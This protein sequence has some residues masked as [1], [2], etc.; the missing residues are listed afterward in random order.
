MTYAQ[1]NSWISATR[2]FWDDYTKWSLDVAP[3]TNAQSFILI[4]NAA[5]KTVSIDEVTSGDFP[6]TMTISNLSVWAPADSTNTLLI[7]DIGTNLPLTVLDSLSISNGG[8]LVI[9]NSAVN[10]SGPTNSF[11]SVGGG[12]VLANGSLL[13]SNVAALGQDP[14]SP[15][16]LTVASGTGSFSGYLCVGLETN[17]VGDVFLLGG[18]LLLT[19][20]PIAVGLY[21]TG[22]LTVTNNSALNSD[23]PVIVG[24]GAGSQGAVTMDNGSWT[25]S[26]HLVTGQDAGAQG[27]VRIN[28]GQLTVTNA[29]L[30]LIGGNGSGQHVWSN[31][32]VTVGALEIGAGH[33][34]QGALT[35]A[36]GTN[37]VQGALFVGTGLTA[38]GVVWMTG[39][40]LITTNAPSFIAP[41]GYGV[42]T[43]SNG[44]WLGNSMLLGSA[45]L[46]TITNIV[47]ELSHGTLNVNGG[48]LTLLAKLVVG[49]CALP[50]SPPFSF[51]V[52]GVGAVNVD[53]GNLYVTNAAHNAFIEVR[54]GTFTLN[55]GTVIVDTF[56]MTNACAH[57]A[58]TG[59]T[60][61]YGSAVLVT[62][63][64]DDADGISN[65]YEQSHGLDPLNAADASIDSDGDGLSNLQEYLAG[66]DATNSASTFRIT[67]IV[68]T[69]NDLH[70]IWMTGTGK[71]N[72]LQRTA[73]DGSGGFA[74]NNFAAIFT[75]TNTTGTVT[76]YLDVDAATHIPA[77]YYRV[78][79][80]P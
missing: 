69:N 17:S 15:G 35:I 23:W 57:F 41:W 34:S 45:S 79:L 2:G 3:S 11:I 27:V 19:N 53:G 13:V 59:G 52:G 71:T 33:G 65:G 40:Q 50:G 9:S 75:A 32:T 22:E 55:S 16:S 67:S 10:V 12:V 64:D 60:L 43:I 56:V 51:A 30:T 7:S 62:N 58:R 25:A 80:V 73:G 46:V 63:R 18:Q 76:N 54:N 4:T 68:R 5:S 21:G 26:G 6:E 70:I 1:A 77:F 72:A 47:G 49:N 36:G 78:R 28:S 20:G 48:T 31:A 38:T 74:T 37:Q 39:G 8:L 14:G 66:T 24:L 44:T 61:I 42:V 29:F